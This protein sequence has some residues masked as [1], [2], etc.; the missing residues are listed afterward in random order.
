MDN[1]ARAQGV[2]NGYRFVMKKIWVE[3]AN[4]PGENIIHLNETK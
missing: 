1:I 3:N 2:S 4:Q